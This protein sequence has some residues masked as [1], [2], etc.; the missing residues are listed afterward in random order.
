MAS[1]RIIQMMTRA[2]G[3]APRAG[4][5]IRGPHTNVRREPFLV[6]QAR[7]VFVCGGALLS[8]KKLTTYFKSSLRLSVHSTFKRQNSVL[9]IW[10]LIGAGA[11]CDGGGGSHGTTGTMDNPALHSRLVGLLHTCACVYVGSGYCYCSKTLDCNDI[12]E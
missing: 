9:K 12:T 6:R 7:I 11:P 8:P 1:V 4:L 2:A 10:Q 5:T 3:G